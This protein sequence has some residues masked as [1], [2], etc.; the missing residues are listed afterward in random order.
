LVTD[1]TVCEDKCIEVFILLGLL[2]H[3]K[4]S[5]FGT[6]IL[7][8]ASSSL[9]TDLTNTSFTKDNLSRSQ[10]KCAILSDIKVNSFFEKI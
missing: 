10:A 1:V 3:R 8:I 4:Y 9:C 6:A 7:L 2:V 5:D